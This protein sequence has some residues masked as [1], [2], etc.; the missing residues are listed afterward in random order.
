ML[1]ILLNLSVEYPDQITDR[2]IREE[3]DT[4]LFE[5]HDTS[6]VALI[7]TSTLLG[8]YQDVQ[9]SLDFDWPKSL[10]IKLKKYRTMP[11]TNCIAFL[12]TQI[13]MRRWKT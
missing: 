1:D 6:S 7:M 10:K 12:V 11:G 9:V 2:D 4:F 5:G 13:G 8:I 3:V